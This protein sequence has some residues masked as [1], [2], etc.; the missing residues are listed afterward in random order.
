MPPYQL[1]SHIIQRKSM[2]SCK[3]PLKSGTMMWCC[4]RM[5]HEVCWRPNGPWITFSASYFSQNLHLLVLLHPSSRQSF[6]AKNSIYLHTFQIS[7]W[8]LAPSPHMWH[9]TNSRKKLS[10]HH[11]CAQRCQVWSFCSA[12]QR[13]LKNMTIRIFL[14]FCLLSVIYI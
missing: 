8:N 6:G 13:K 5:Y 3:T 4:V 11:Y 14:V 2:L 12:L 9:N 7:I 10:R 1:R